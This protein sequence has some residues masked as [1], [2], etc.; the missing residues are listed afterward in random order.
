MNQVSNYG[1]VS[2]LVDGDSLSFELRATEP[3]VQ[4]LKKGTADGWM[5]NWATSS[6]KPIIYP[7]A[8][9]QL[10]A[11]RKP[12]VTGTEVWSYNGTYITFSAE[13]ISTAPASING[14][15]K[16]LAYNNGDFEVP[17]LQIIKNLASPT[18]VDTDRIELSCQVE[19]SGIKVPTSNGIDIRL[20]ETVGDP[21]QG[22]ISATEGGV[23]D[24]NTPSITLTAELMKG[25]NYV[26]TGVTYK[27]FKAVLG[28]W[29]AITAVTGSPNKIKKTANDID[30]TSIIRCEF[31]IDS[32][33]VFASQITISDETDPLILSMNPSGITTLPKGASVTYRPKVVKRST[34]VVDASYN[35]LTFTTYNAKGEAIT[36]PAS[37]K[38]TDS[39]TI[40]RADVD[41][42]FGQVKVYVLATK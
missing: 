2:A 28:G 4:Y 29:E 37:Q 8:M 26:T 12:I 34:G 1:V 39:I 27:W 21:Y 31:Y 16:K 22:H 35:K 9:S 14:V 15:F 5:P 19:V 10:E 23:I 41:N 25:G 38:T 17:G 30:A 32:M 6:R 40:T 20:E 42:N 33:M 36:I 11:R 13:G 3:L 24:D 7:N 18:N